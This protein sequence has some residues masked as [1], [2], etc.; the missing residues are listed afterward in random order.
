MDIKQLDKEYVANTYNRFDLALIQGKGSRVVD[1]QG[2]EYID[3]GSGIGVNSLGYCDEEWVRA[4]SQQAAKL[5]HTSNLYY[6]EPSAIL[7]KRFCEASGMKKVFFANSGAEANEGSIKTA[8]KYS[9]DKYG[10]G[11]NVIVSL[12]N[13]FHGRTM[14]ALA[15]TGQ[16][17]FHRYFFPFDSAVRYT[18]A[19][20]IEAMKDAL[21]AEDVCAVIMEM[22]QGEGGVIKLDENF[23]EQTVNLAGERDILVI[24]DEVQTGVGRTG[25]FTAYQHYG[26]TPDIASFAKGLG[27]GLPIGAVALGEKV[28]NTLAQGTHAT[29][30]G[31][32]PVICAGANVV[33]SKLIE[34]GIIES[35]DS[36]AEY[37]RESLKDCKEVVDI[38]GL[39]LMMG[40][41]LRSKSA[42][43]VACECID[44]GLIVLTA[45]DK[46]RLLPPLNITDKELEE[47]I[48]ILKEVL[49]S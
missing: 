20:D 30:F 13:S 46:I 9:Y 26:F 12:V 22:V 18:P 19:N 32:N 3:F 43:E 21:K 49:N 29:T 25:K 34:G 23:V 47:G 8:R 44:K 45:K 24:V 5:Q 7:A 41:T 4:V 16:E 11:R 48:A 37:I 31:G 10:E 33:L 40:I 36:K 1:E 27:G 14:E 42:R 15:L 38:S 6:N 17:V 28:V 2:K 35:V 39:G